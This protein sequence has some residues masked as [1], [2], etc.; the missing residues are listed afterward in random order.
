VCWRVV[1]IVTRVAGGQQVEKLWWA[2]RRHGEA[3]R[4]LSRE[5]H[6]WAQTSLAG[7]GSP[8]VAVGHKGVLGSAGY[9]GMR[10]E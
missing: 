2:A 7:G 4:V 6:P 8:R 3:K 5:L 10:V 1:G 9:I